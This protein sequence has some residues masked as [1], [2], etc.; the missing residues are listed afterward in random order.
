MSKL[1]KLVGLVEVLVALF[2]FCLGVS[3]TLGFIA[4][5]KFAGEWGT[6]FIPI[7]FIVATVFGW[8]GYVLLSRESG[9]WMHQLFPLVTVVLLLVFLFW[10]DGVWPG[11]I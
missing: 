7:D 2:A 10:A 4:N 5:H 11:A 1:A 9:A 8:A 3:M 6:L